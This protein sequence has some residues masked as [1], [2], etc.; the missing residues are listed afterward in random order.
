[1]KP[2]YIGFDGQ[3]PYS[4]IGWFVDGVIKRKTFTYNVDEHQ[5]ILAMYH[6]KIGLYGKCDGYTVQYSEVKERVA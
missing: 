4:V 2:T 3:T 6:N 5:D 1:M